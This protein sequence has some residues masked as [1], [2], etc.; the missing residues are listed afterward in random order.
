MAG[1]FFHA[2]R[3]PVLRDKEEKKSEDLYARK[4][5]FAFCEQA[6][7]VILTSATEREERIST[8]ARSRGRGLFV[9]NF[10]FG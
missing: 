4:S 8:E 9:Q 7:L 3:E 10:L 1:A 5:G 2:A 6:S